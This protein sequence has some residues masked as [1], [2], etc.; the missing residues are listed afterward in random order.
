MAISCS[1]SDC[2]VMATGKCLLLHANPEDCP[3]YI[4][5]KDA[6]PPEK[7]TSEASIGRRFAPSLE[8]GSQDAAELMRGH[9]ATLVGVL[10]Q[11]DVGKTCFLVSLYLLAS[12]GA[13]GDDFE[14]AGSETLGGFEVRA[15]NLRHWNKGSLPKQLVDHTHLA[16]PRVPALLHMALR[17]RA[18]PRRRFDLL[19]TDLPGEWSRE[20]VDDIATAA[21][22]RFLARADGLI[23]VLDGPQFTSTARHLAVHRAQLLLERLALTIDIDRTIPMVLLVSKADEFSL[24]VPES[25]DAVTQRAKELGF[26][27]TVIPV[28]AISRSPEKVRSGTGVMDVLR[29]FLRA[30][31]VSTRALYELPVVGRRQFSRLRE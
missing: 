5:D 25:V 26:V 7:M 28:A 6:L 19:L 10:G 14:F 13:L 12:C 22:L 3:D 21:R 27:P 17:Q 29:Y 24:R 1:N 30:T 18:A 9:Y 4:F 16:D 2:T 23:I 31:L 11:Y 8:L 15:R 20:L